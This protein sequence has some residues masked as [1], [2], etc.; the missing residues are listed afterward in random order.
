M[1]VNK[2]LYLSYCEQNRVDDIKKDF[3]VLRG[4]MIDGLFLLERKDNVEAFIELLNFYYTD[5]DL[6]SYTRLLKNSYSPEGNKCFDYLISRLLEYS[7]DDR[8]MKQLYSCIYEALDM[9]DYYR[10]QV[11]CNLKNK[12]MNLRAGMWRKALQQEYSFEYICSLNEKVASLEQ[13]CLVCMNNNSEWL[14]RIYNSSVG[15]TVENFLFCVDV[16]S[17]IGMKFYNTVY[18]SDEGY[19]WERE[20][21]EVSAL[22]KMIDDFVVRSISSDLPE[23]IIELKKI[24]PQI[25]FSKKVWSI[26]WNTDKLQL[27]FDLGFSI[28]PVIACKIE[29]KIP[30][31][32][33]EK[34]CYEDNEI[35]VLRILLR[36]K[37]IDYDTYYSITNEFADTNVENY[38]AVYIEVANIHTGN[39]LFINSMLN[40][41]LDV[42]YTCNG[43]SL[44]T[45][46]SRLGDTFACRLL[47]SKGASLIEGKVR[48]CRWWS[49]YLLQDKKFDNSIEMD[50]RDWSRDYYYGQ[51]PAVF[52]A[53]WY[54]KS[55]ELLDLYS[56]M[57]YLD[58]IVFIKKKRI[59][60]KR[61]L[62]SINMV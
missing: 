51:L 33:P 9:K 59:A 43:E 60:C 37:L 42:N 39:E 55:E 31:E 20:N 19:E 49:E 48:M 11:L 6:K 5:L 10:L 21:T 2:K 50:E 15:T 62:D 23:K 26:N 30:V 52:A 25:T 14:Q 12:E 40:N 47:I 29:R 4:Y 3:P 41:G 8:V 1:A 45:M 36:K 58:F 17:N 18:H 28:N 16:F 61:Y 46:C 57:G 22:N 54:N 38:A 13:T 32:L 24:N 53:A 27:Y 44:L 34:Y 35:D 56:K 7:E